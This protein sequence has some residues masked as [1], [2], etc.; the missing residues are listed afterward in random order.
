MALGLAALGLAALLSASAA[1]APPAA[2]PAPYWTAPRP[3]PSRPLAGYPK[4]A[5][6]ST[7]VVFYGTSEDGSYNHGAMLQYS[8]GVVT[9]AWKNGLNMSGE[10]AAGQR[11]KYV[12]TAG[13][14][15]GEW[16]APAVLFDSMSTPELP[17]ALFA[18][19]FA[20]LG[21]SG[22]GAGRLYASATPAVIA[23]GDAQGSQFCLWP[24][25]LDPRNA[26]PP[27]QTQPVGT[28]L[29]RR[30]LPGLGQLGPVFWA[31]DVVPTG[32]GPASAAAGILTA[33]ETDAQTQAD[34]AELRA[35]RLPG[36]GVPCAD[37]AASG[38]LKCEACDGGCQ[39]YADLPH[40]ASL[41]NERT[42]WKV[43]AG[44]AYAGADV[45]LYRCGASAFYAST[46]PAAG[47]AGAWSSI[48]LTDIP[49]DNTNMNAGVL[50]GDL[51]VM[52]VLNPLPHS[53]RD[54][55]VL[56]VSADGLNISA[57]G[58]VM[59]CT[60]LGVAN[61]TCGGRGSHDNPGPSYPQAL[62]VVAP[63]PA[64]MQGVWV[65]ATNNK[66]DVVVARLPFSA[67]PTP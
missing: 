3:D 7:R 19:P 43:P 1:A 2:V 54:P 52:L 63:A 42:H 14:G 55:L 47:P 61:S 48:S 33:N 67:L 65:V 9:V 59:T 4:L 20:T 49:N 23:T 16:T 36:G 50:P 25:G 64:E 11:V 41:A 60:D 56:A 10:D 6:S 38:S 34:V 5:V 29:L 21:A 40:N 37:A 58:V 44:A 8:E 46:R 39:V 45:L 17:A 15:A 32:F 57:A 62:S 22:G 31:A 66:Q 28:L 27:G 53:I 12:Q 51:G 13:A 26:G 24:D 30:V 18:G 35:T